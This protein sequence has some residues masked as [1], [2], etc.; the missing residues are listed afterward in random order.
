MQPG[1]KAPVHIVACPQHCPPP[2]VRQQQNTP[3]LSL[4]EALSTGVVAHKMAAAIKMDFIMVLLLTMFNI[5]NYLTDARN[6]SNEIGVVYVVLSDTLGG[7]KALLL[8]E[9][10]TKIPQRGVPRWRFT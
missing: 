8:D 6:K 2:I 7:A 3:W 9:R 10:L 1:T 5:P 4:R